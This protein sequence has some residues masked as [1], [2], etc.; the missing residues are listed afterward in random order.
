[1]NAAREF[2]TETEWSGA[3][4]ASLQLD[5][6]SFLVIRVLLHPEGQC[7][8]DLDI[9]SMQGWAVGENHGVLVF[10]EECGPWPAEQGLAPLL[11][12]PGSIP[13]AGK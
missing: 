6:S 8:L 4:V 9:V 12:S 10:D 13:L 3:D 1:M 5:M 11:L 2:F 7:P